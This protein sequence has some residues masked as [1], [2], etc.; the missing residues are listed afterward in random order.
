ME[1]ALRGA[2][3]RCYLWRSY[4]LQIKECWGETGESPVGVKWV[5][6]K[7]GANVGTREKP[8]DHGR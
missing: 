1:R 6:V 7:V 4:D 8:E 2:V 3:L 5:D